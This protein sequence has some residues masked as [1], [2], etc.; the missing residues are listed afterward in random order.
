MIQASSWRA[1]GILPSRPFNQYL[2]SVL[3]LENS[4]AVLALHV[5]DSKRRMSYVGLSYENDGFIPSVP[6]ES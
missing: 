3:L 1:Y 5:E 2:W 4:L 6:P